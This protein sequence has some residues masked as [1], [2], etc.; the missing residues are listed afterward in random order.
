MRVHTKVLAKLVFR[1]D[2]R[3]TKQPSAPFSGAGIPP[4]RS[5]GIARDVA[6]SWVSFLSSSILEWV[7]KSGLGGAQLR[8]VCARFARDLGCKTCP[9]PRS[10]GPCGHVLAE[11][12]WK[13][14]S[15]QMHMMEGWGGGGG[16]KPA[17][18]G[19]GLREVW[20]LRAGK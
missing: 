16:K 20:V 12:K 11:G 19:G 17:P 2:P 18:V 7:L 15:P 3:P 10:M 1:P 14:G 6:V 13:S 4:L 5:A 9:A 8:A